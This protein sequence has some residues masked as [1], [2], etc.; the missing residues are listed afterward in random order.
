M[1]VPGI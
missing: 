1:W